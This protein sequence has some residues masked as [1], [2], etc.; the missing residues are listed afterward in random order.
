MPHVGLPTSV[1]AIPRLLRDAG[2]AFGPGVTVEVACGPRKRIS[3]APAGECTVEVDWAGR[4][5]RFAAASRAR[6]SPRVLEEAVRAAQDRARVLGLRP[7][8]ILPFLDEDRLDRLAGVGVSGL[9]L[10]GNGIIIAPGELFLRRS[11]C[12]N[13]FPETRPVR[14]AYR[15]ATAL[16]PRVFVRRQRFESVSAVRSEI[17]LAGGELALST[18]SKALA[19][20]DEDLVIGRSPRGIEL[21]QPETVLDLLRAS[22]VPPRALGSTQLRWSAPIDTL[23]A[24][25]AG[26]GSED[27]GGLRLVLSG[28][29]SCAR[30]TAG[31]RADLPTVFVSDL[32]EF[33]RRIGDAWAPTD[34]FADVRV[35]ETDDPGAFFDSVRKNGAVRE[36]SALQA[37]LELATG[38]DKRDREMAEQVR[39][40]ILGQI[41]GAA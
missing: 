31:L 34:R 27:G 24:A 4:K 13:R 8:V 7:M 20:M 10:S 12:P 5:V 23:F 17:A 2:S 16:V 39:A 15:G 35:V 19:R 11:G 14:F 3:A 29:S 28:A 30:Y 40:R 18:V 37:Y 33:R 32:G 21:L 22:F 41:A 25:A 1:D 26:L 6:G 38:G 9:D 36:A